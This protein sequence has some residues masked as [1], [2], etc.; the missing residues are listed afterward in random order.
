M[1]YEFIHDLAVK[2]PTV[3]YLYNQYYIDYTI[4][5]DAM[6]VA[7]II[8]LS[9]EKDTFKTSLIKYIDRFGTIYE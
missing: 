8:H 3:Y 6:L 1:F 9:E 2:D 5:Y 7:I 4:S